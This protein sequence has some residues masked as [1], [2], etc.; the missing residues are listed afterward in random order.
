[1]YIVRD[2]NNYID[3]PRTLFLSMYRNDYGYML[4]NFTFSDDKFEYQFLNNW[5]YVISLETGEFDKMYFTNEIAVKNRKQIFWNFE[6]SNCRKLTHKW[7]LY[8]ARI[9]RNTMQKRFATIYKRFFDYKLDFEYILKEFDD[10]IN[11]IKFK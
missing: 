8:Y 3:L 6:C 10:K 11:N 9:L 1:M 2:E 5:I 4:P 7:F